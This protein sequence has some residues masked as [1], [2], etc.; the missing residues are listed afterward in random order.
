MR[1]LNRLKNQINILELNSDQ[2]QLKKA[3]R[4]FALGKYDVLIIRA[5]LQNDPDTDLFNDVMEILSKA[6]KSSIKE[7]I[8][9]PHDKSTP[10]HVDNPQQ[11]GWRLAIITLAGHQQTW[12]FAKTKLFKSSQI[13]RLSTQTVSGKVRIKPNWLSSML[14]TCSINPGDLV[15]HHS[16]ADSPRKPSVAHS[17]SRSISGTN[18]VAWIT[19]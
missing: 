13:S 4:L 12:S 14:K 6:T 3:L 7:P 16:T 9:V 1:L 15:V 8:T 2:K 18:R 10:L 19:V 11:I 17:V 5:N